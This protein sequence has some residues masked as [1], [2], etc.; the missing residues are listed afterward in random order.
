M[1]TQPTA[2]HFAGITDR[3]E[4]PDQLEPLS[5]LSKLEERGTS[6]VQFPPL[7]TALLD[8][9]MMVVLLTDRPGS[10][11]LLVYANYSRP[12]RLA[13]V[14]TA[15]NKC[16]GVFSKR[17]VFHSITK[18]T[19]IVSVSSRGSL[20]TLCHLPHSAIL[21]LEYIVIPAPPSVLWQAA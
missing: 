11:D 16:F 12:F 19:A 9:R 6:P 3:T 5:F 7:K 20:L 8:L 14:F 18:A 10:L 4:V 15:A 21:P 13:G 2:S 1:A 17:S